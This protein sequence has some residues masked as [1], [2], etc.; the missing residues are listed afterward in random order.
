MRL[1]SPH[2]R[3]GCCVVESILGV[4]HFGL[5][6]RSA[7]TLCDGLAGHVGSCG[8]VL[9]PHVQACLQ[10]IHTGQVGQE[11]AA[12]LVVGEVFFGLGQV[13]IDE[14]FHLFAAGTG[15]LGQLCR[16]GLLGDDRHCEVGQILSR[17]GIRLGGITGQ[18][19]IHT[20]HIQIVH[21]S[22]GIAQSQIFLQLVVG[23]A[24]IDGSYQF[25]YRRDG[26]FIEAPDVPSGCMTR[27]SIFV[28]GP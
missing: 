2:P 17:V 10:T 9:Y 13:A 16:C 23:L 5:A 28:L 12:A 19:L 4:Q 27:T 26:V 11:L 18:I 20:C 21:G 1:C 15:Q 6:E 24:L 25:V 14:C 22:E 8:I 3:G 7:S